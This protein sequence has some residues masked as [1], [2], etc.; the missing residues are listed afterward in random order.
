MASNIFSRIGTLLNRIVDIVSQGSLERVRILR[1]FNL[2]FQE[3]FQSGDIDR[4]CTVT[5]SPG[6]INFKHELSTF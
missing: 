1:E 3:A 4:H 6:N 2:V 5:T